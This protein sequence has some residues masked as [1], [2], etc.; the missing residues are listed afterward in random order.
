MDERVQR[1]CF[2][3][4]TSGKQK[5]FKLSQQEHGPWLLLLKSGTPLVSLY[6]QDDDDDDDDDDYDDDAG[7]VVR[8]PQHRGSPTHREQDLNLRGRLS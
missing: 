6:Y 8:D 4:D 1:T 3:T 5:N 2:V 7:T